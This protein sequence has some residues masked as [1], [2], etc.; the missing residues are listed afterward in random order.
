MKKVGS[1]LVL[2]LTLAACG[3]GKDNSN[4]TVQTGAERISFN[5]EVKSALS[6]ESAQIPAAMIVK[7]SLDE[8]G[9]EIPASAEVRAAKEIGQ[10]AEKT[11]SV[12]QAHQSPAD[13]DKF[14]IV[15][16]EATKAQSVAALKDTRYVGVQENERN[17]AAVDSNV[18]STVG[19]NGLIVTGSNNY[20][21]FNQTNV[22]SDLNGAQRS[23]YDYDAGRYSYNV[24]PTLYGTGC[25]GRVGCWGNGYYQYGYR[26]VYRSAYRGWGGYNGYWG[27]YAAPRRNVFGRNCY[28]TYP[29]PYYGYGAGYSA[30]GYNIYSW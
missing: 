30:A 1:L 28:Y 22:N 24:R 15:N 25:V 3:Q 14:V 23:S 9:K 29:S 12:A 5:D 17:A 6:N 4:E 7:V 26:P 16:P 11:F 20:T 18:A 19:N 2:A 21:Y 8:N 13:A 10:D 27:Y